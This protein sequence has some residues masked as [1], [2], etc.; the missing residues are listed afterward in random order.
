MECAG[1]TDVGGSKLISS[2]H[3]NIL[4]GQRLFVF[5][6]DIEFRLSFLPIYRLFSETGSL[7]EEV[8]NEYV[9]SYCHK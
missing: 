1:G 4:K 3:T 6:D 5:I 9:N 7:Q 8:Y 2:I